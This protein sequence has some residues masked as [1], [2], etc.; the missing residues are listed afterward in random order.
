MAQILWIPDANE[1]VGWCDCGGMQYVQPATEGQDEFGLK[2]AGSFGQ[3]GFCCL[4]RCDS[5]GG[6][7]HEVYP[8]IPKE[9]NN[10]TETTP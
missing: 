4:L 9:T 7:N 3:T 8:Y 10:E 1:Q 2:P 6:F 5:C